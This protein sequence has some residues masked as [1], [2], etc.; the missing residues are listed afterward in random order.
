[1]PDIQTQ[2]TDTI[3]KPLSTGFGINR[4][5]VIALTSSIILGGLTG[6]IMASKPRG[7]GVVSNLPGQQPKTAS[8]DTRTFRDFAEGTI[9][10]KPQP[11]NSTQYT[12]GTHI[13]ER[14][15][16]VPVTLTSSV[17]DLS[18]YEGKKVK[19]QGETQKALQSG[20]LM[21]VGKIEEL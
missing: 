16:Q 12:E 3:T 21:D 9:K 5:V 4:I 1:M 2:E 20:W 14:E 11:K 6:Y 8:Q 17:V 18:K 15:G 19:V 10:V 13:L 7:S